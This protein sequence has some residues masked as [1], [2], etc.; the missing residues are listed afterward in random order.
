[1]LHNAHVYQYAFATNNYE[2]YDQLEGND[3]A[4]SDINSS[5]IEFQYQAPFWELITSYTTTQTTHYTATH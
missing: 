2:L 1:M 3:I 5:Y 4:Y